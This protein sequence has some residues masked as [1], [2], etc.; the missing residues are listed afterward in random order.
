MRL[1]AI[2]CAAAAQTT[3]SPKY[4]AIN[5][6]PQHRLQADLNGDGIPDVL[7]SENNGQLKEL[8]SNGNA[9]YTAVTPSAPESAYT[10]LASGDFNGDGKNDVFFYD[11]T[12]GSK[13]FVVGTET[14]KAASVPFSRRR[15][16]PE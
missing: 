15:I 7:I 9:S 16:Y 4:V 2:C 11:A 6:Y 3:F 5:Q 1:G 13:L 10:P 12:G 8:L 14:G